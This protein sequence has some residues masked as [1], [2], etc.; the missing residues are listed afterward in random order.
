[1]D[2]LDFIRYQEMTF[3]AYCKRIV[4][5]EYRNALRG[6]I[7]REKHEITF[8]MLADAEVMWFSY[9]DNY[10]LESKVFDIAQDAVVVQDSEIAD[11]LAALPLC[12]RRIILL[13]YFMRQNDQQIGEM[14]GLSAN[15]IYYRRR[16]SILKMQRILEKYRNEV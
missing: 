9:E 16:H 4:K 14:L 3:D 15:A 2:I 8:S 5:N 6:I 13:F 11:A 7:R 1:M 12:R 10:D